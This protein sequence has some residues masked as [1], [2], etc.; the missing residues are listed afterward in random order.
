MRSAKVIVMGVV[1]VTVL[2]AALP[3][4]T[5]PVKLN[6]PKGWPTP[7]YEL[8]EGA[9]TREGIDLG[10]RLFHDP[11]LSKDS[12]ISCSSCHLSYTAFSH[13]DHK[14]SH[15]IRDSIGTRNAPAL[16]NL[17][18][19]RTF[20]WDGAVNHL[21]VQ[22]LAPIEHKAE[23]GEELSHVVMKLQRNERY[24]L[25]F[26]SAFGDGPVTGEHLLKALAQFQLTLICIG[27]KY[28]RVMNSAEA[29]TD[30]EANGYRL[31][32][33][34]CSSCHAEP[35]FTDG[36]FRN[37]GLA[38]DSVLRD[39]GRI[40]ITHEAKDSLCFKVPSL[41]NVEFSYP[42]MH[43][44]RFKNLRDVIAHYM[45]GIHRSN[46]LAK[47]LEKPIV[48]TSNERTDLLAFLL[49]LTDRDF[50]LNPA[51]ATPMN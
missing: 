36:S 51:H 39:G 21:D 25:L 47:E 26:R 44:G 42:Y 30:Q 2:V 29:F 17:A 4:S 20:M 41:R 34:N 18:W 48:L 8:K 24:R 1:C 27:S 33:A 22:A 7:V 23:M 31:F 35:L 45:G 9:L 32:V 5:E 28:D 15:G 50:L 49:T 40:R 19:N 43:D 13:V 37:N 10:R 46:T 16:M 14:L 12:T 6:V 3:L 38:P 11:I